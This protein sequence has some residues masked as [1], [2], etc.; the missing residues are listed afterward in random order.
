MTSLNDL[1][2]E[3]SVHTSNEN[4]EATFE[5]SYE[6]L[7]TSPHNIKAL[8]LTIVSLINLER[9]TQALKILNQFK[10]IDQ[11]ELV[12]ERAYVY[13]KLGK[14]ADLAA[15]FAGF[16]QEELSQNPGL[17][18]LKAQALYRSGDYSSA[19]EL[20]QLLLLDT[21][22][23][24][25]ADLKVNER[26]VLSDALTSGKFG[27]K[28]IAGFE[29]DKDSSSYDLIFNESLI[30]L[31]F[32]DYAKSLELLQKAQELSEEINADQDDR[33]AETIPIIIQKAYVYQ[34]AGE[35][36]KAKEIL[37]E[38]QTLQFSDELIQL[39][40]N[41]NLI[42]VFTNGQQQQPNPRLTLREL[43]LPNAIT[44]LS[45]RLSQIQQNALLRN[46]SKLCIQIGKN[47][48]SSSPLSTD[49]TL[50]ALSLLQ[51]KSRVEIDQQEPKTQ[52]KLSTRA[53]L[54]SQN[55]ALALISAQLNINAGRFDAAVA[56][57][58]NLPVEDKLI[59]AVVSTLLSLYEQQGSLKKKTELFDLVYSKFEDS[60]EFTESD[61]E[62][63]KIFALKFSTSQY[64]KSQKI[65]NK[66]QS[67]NSNDQIINLVLS[68]ESNSSLPLIS[69]LTANIDISSLEEQAIQIITSETQTTKPFKIT[70][71]QR[72]RKNKLTID[73]TKTLDL[74]RWLPMKDRSYY[75]PKKSKKKA[76]ANATQGGAADNITEVSTA[77]SA[78]S[79]PAPS[80]ASKSKNKK[81]GKK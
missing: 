12:L 71:R 37:A 52:A 11:S 48:P 70:K 57:L 3:L 59:S 32:N 34:I 65:L 33:L 6:I 77:T 36:D 43:N 27:R 21:S 10:G 72:T 39:I 58:E 18:H 75:K 64:E 55:V 78:R 13:Y 68:S 40:L 7:K 15:I 9:Y 41:T 4:H 17:L 28:D 61:F 46:Y 22:E 74:E 73:T 26:A 16:S 31:G 63:L 49:L 30:Y 25:L 14:E 8:R 35:L 2:K 1:F 79:S 62:L 69:D 80:T 44:K 67:F 20:Y 60:L 19:L 42:S 38:L 53:A 56:V 24:E 81:K 29:L 51:S 66:L 76:A 54:K 50:V 47:I 5:T 45:A 23:H